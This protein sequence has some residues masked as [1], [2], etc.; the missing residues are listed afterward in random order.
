M[1]S[2]RREL[3]LRKIESCGVWDREMNGLLSWPLPR[4]EKEKLQLGFN[5][6]VFGRSA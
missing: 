6:F 5:V 2:R 1:G 3:L 4:A